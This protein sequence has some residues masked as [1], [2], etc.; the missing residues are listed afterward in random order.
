MST[1]TVASL[2]DDKVTSLAASWIAGISNAGS[3]RVTVDSVPV[4]WNSDTAQGHGLVLQTEM[5][6]SFCFQPCLE[7]HFFNARN[8]Y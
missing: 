6:F 4:I 3:D 7:P 1:K 2:D 5:L 8:K